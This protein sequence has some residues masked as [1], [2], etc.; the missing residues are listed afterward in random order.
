MEMKDI[1]KDISARGNGSIYLGVVGT[2]RTGKSTFIKK[3]VETLIIP[4]IDD[5]FERKRALD[6]IP[7]SSGGKTIM[8]IEPKFVPNN[9]AKVKIDDLTCNMRLV[10]CVGYVIENSK[11]YEDENGPRMVKT[12]WYSEEIPFVE[13]AEIGTEKVIKDHSTIGIIVTTDGSIGDFERKDYID[14]LNYSILPE[15][16]KLDGDYTVFCEK[17]RHT[18]GDKNDE[19]KFFPLRDFFADHLLP[20]SNELVEEIIDYKGGTDSRKMS[21]EQVEGFAK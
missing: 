11:G 9:I 10:D 16:A 2:V 1:I 6:E 8:T 18:Y 3:I 5:E 20:N 12:P 19:N 15:D 7:Q 21:A 4:N 13:A 14:A 17:M